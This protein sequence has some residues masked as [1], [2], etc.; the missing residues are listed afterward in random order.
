M[1]PTFCPHL[2]LWKTRFFKA[3]AQDGSD[4]L[5]PKAC[6]KVVRSWGTC[7]ITKQYMMYIWYMIY[8][9]KY[10]YIWCILYIWWLGLSLKLDLL[11]FM[12]ILK[13]RPG[14]QVWLNSRNQL[15]ASEVLQDWPTEMRSSKD[16][17]FFFSD[18]SR[19][20]DWL[21]LVDQCRRNSLSISRICTVDAT[22]QAYLVGFSKEWWV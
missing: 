2:F 6:R 1:K 15:D 22:N 12:S 8:I 18:A 5:G 20:S 3:T 17:M 14:E 19:T 16:D 13:G 11:Q 7:D 10:I 21:I 4:L 9:Y